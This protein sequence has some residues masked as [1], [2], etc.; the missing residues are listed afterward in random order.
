MTVFA[1]AKDNKGLF[2][3][4]MAETEEEVYNYCDNFR[5]VPKG[6]QMNLFE[7]EGLAIENWASDITPAMAQSHFTWVGTRR[8]NPFVVAKPIYEYKDGVYVG[9]KEFKEKF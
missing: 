2:H 5:T 7:K 1:Q 9:L 4:L 8:N 6:S 3:Y